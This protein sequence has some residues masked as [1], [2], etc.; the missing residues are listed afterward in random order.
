MGASSTRPPLLTSARRA[1]GG[2]AFKLRR[3][4]GAAGASAAGL[5]GLSAPAFALSTL[6]LEGERLSVET[7]AILLANENGK[8]ISDSFDTLAAAAIPFLLA[9]LLFVLFKLAKLFASAF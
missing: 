4:V 8:W 7:A 6:P 1:R 5:V 9:G 3:G 2:E